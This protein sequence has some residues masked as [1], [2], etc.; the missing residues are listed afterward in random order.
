MR[1]V[2]KKGVGD[3]VAV[4]LPG[5]CLA[6]R[7]RRCHR[8]EKERK[9]M[10]HALFGIVHLVEIVATLVGVVYAVGFLFTAKPAKG[11]IKL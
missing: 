1:P 5:T 6:R 3:R 7:P 4:S 2:Q 10:S 8:T 11:C 9:Q